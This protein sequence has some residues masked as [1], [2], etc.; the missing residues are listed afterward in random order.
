M[1][2]LEG[3]EWMLTT[4]IND[5]VLDGIEWFFYTYQRTYTSYGTYACKKESLG[6]SF[7]RRATVFPCYN[8]VGF[9]CITTQ[10]KLHIR[11]PTATI[12]L[13]QEK[14]LYVA[15]VEKQVMELKNVIV[16]MDFHQDVE[17]PSSF[18]NTS[19]SLGSNDMEE[20]N[21]QLLPFTQE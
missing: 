16:F 1:W 4:G 10:I 21:T 5:S 20:N 8:K 6:L 9:S 7:T 12:Y 17:Q 14:N 13:S 15:I 3:I 19:I 18:A 2:L 11:R